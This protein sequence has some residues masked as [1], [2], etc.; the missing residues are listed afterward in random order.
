M[1]NALGNRLAF[2]VGGDVL[3]S[4]GRIGMPVNRTSRQ[5]LTRS[6]DVHLQNRRRFGIVLV[7]DK[8]AKHMCAVTR[9]ARRGSWQ[10][11]HT[12]S[13]GRMSATL[14]IGLG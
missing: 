14:G 12:C 9:N 10:C 13:A 6:A 1:K 7:V 4:N 8:F 11:P 3:D 2:A 5:R